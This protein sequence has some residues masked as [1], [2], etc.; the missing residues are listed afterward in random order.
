MSKQASSISIQP[1]RSLRKNRERSSAPDFLVKAG[2]MA[3]VGVLDDANAVVGSL[4][5]NQRFQLGQTA[6]SCEHGRLS[7]RFLLRITPPWM[8]SDGSSGVLSYFL[9]PLGSN[10]IAYFTDYEHWF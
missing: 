2:K 10:L 3:T 6:H 5:P 7:G 4:W 1:R 9:V 8:R